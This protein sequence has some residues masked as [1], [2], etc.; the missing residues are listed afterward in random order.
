MTEAVW[1]PTSE[2]TGGG[3]SVTDGLD[4]LHASPGL[5]FEGKHLAW[6]SGTRSDRSGRAPAVF[7]TASPS[8]ASD[9]GGG[10][11]REE[12]LISA[13]R[14]NTCKIWMLISSY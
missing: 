10:A 8:D 6:L 11:S 1:P 12:A 7:G 9:V 5:L 3:G 2:K 4:K 14:A 13:S